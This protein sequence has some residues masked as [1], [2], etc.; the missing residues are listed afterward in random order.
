MKR[1]QNCSFLS[2]F[3]ASWRKTGFTLLKEWLSCLTK[4][5]YAH[6]WEHFFSFPSTL[7]MCGATLI[8]CFNLFQY[9]GRKWKE[10]QKDKAYLAAVLILAFL[11]YSDQTSKWL[12][13][14][15]ICTPY[16][17]GFLSIIFHAL[18][19]FSSLHYYGTSPDTMVLRICLSTI[20]QS[21][22]WMPWWNLLYLLYW[23]TYFF[24]F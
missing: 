8:F 2:E 7:L 20:A 6:S 15:F 18:S 1:S 4:G 5:S 16:E 12:L 24:C 22:Q 10:Q 11:W 13:P 21:K 9:I 17:S 14:F 19:Y 23:H 3:T